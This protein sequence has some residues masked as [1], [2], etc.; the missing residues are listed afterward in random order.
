MY[1]RSAEEVLEMMIELLLQY[2][3]E[4]FPYKNREGDLFQ[5]GERTAYTECLEWIQQWKYARYNGLTFDIEKI[6]PL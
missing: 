6:Y 2:L 3:E 1:E 5:Y 4:L